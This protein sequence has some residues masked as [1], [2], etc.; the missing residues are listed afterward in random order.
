MVSAVGPN[1][2]TVFLVSGGAR[3]I[4][5]D[6]VVALARRF[7]SAFI[8]VGRSAY[9]SRLDLSWTNGATDEAGLKRAAMVHLSRDGSRPTPREIQRAAAEVLTHWEIAGTLKAV[10]DAGGRAAYVVADVTDGEA[11]SRAVAATADAI[12]PVT[13]IIHGAGV[14]ADKLVHQKSLADFDRVLSVKVDGLRN[15]LACVPL[16]QLRYLVL[17]SSVAGFYGNAGQADYAAANEALNKA[18]HWVREHAPDCRV[19]A[20]DWGPWDGGM[21]T[22][23]LKKQLALR[24][25]DVIPVEEGTQALVTLLSQNEGG[26]EQ[27]AQVVIGSP[28]LPPRRDAPSQERAYRVRRKLTL[29]Q[30][31]FLLDHVI[32]GRAVLPTVCAVSWMVNACEQLYPGYQFLR[33]DDYRVLKGVVFDQELADTYALDVTA[34]PALDP[35][36]ISFD[37]LIWSGCS[38]TA[39][40]CALGKQN[41][42]PRYHYRAQVTLQCSNGHEQPPETGLTSEEWLDR[43]Q[44]VVSGRSLYQDGT[45]FHGPTF[46]GIDAILRIDDDGLTMRASLPPMRREDQGQ[47]AVQSFNPFLIDVQLQSLLVWA[48]RHLGHVGLPLRIQ[49]GIQ[50][51]PMPFGEV[52]VTSMHVRSRSALSLVADVEIRNGA[53]AL[54]MA[55]KGAEITLSAR[56][57]EL[58][59]QNRVDAAGEGL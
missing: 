22:P 53:G 24:A 8:L 23:E 43:G 12:G 11:L 1:E 48:K 19:V 21:V 35:D 54:C 52:F 2:S 13:G 30:N 58:F 4:T 46:Q 51:R 5:A 15:L 25:I 9:A 18:A 50:Y 33:V 56:L 49:Q 7:R 34:R 3:G 17:F 40:E 45:L 14:L 41:G 28:L 57:N 6:C 36:Q 27:A 55:V 44:A 47:F 38:A 39:S 10:A 26:R 37:A 20:V 29:A 16:D 59:L 31:P 32:G 42:L